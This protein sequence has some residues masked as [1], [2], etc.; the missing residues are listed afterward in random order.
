M[1][2]HLRIVLTSTEENSSVTSILTEIFAL[3]SLLSLVS[4]SPVVVEGVSIKV[5]SLCCEKLA[6][7]YEKKL[8]KS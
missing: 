4:K 3:T 1:Y 8:L 7:K 5:L 2:I 6:L